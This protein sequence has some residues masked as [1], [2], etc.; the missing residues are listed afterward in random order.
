MLER[1][2][3]PRTGG[4]SDEH[5]RY[6]LSLDFSPEEQVRYADLARQVQ[7]GALSEQEQADLDEFAAANSLL[8]ILQSKARISLK[9]HNHAA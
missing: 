1:V 2:I 7:L 8:M 9:K 4:F 6:I 3:Q 5:A